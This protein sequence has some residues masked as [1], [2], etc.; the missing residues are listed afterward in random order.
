MLTE[1]L[2]VYGPYTRKDGRKHVVI[3]NNNGTKTTKS[4]PRYLM[5]QHLGR[6]LEPSE[7]VLMSP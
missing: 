1:S 6:S 7:I 4:Y 5:E 2:K 3:V